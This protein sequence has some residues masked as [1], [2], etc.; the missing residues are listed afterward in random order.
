MKYEMKCVKFECI[1]IWMKINLST[2]YGVKCQI[3]NFFL[4]NTLT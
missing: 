3:V 4:K 2:V 1:D